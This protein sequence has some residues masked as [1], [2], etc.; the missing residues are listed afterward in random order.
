MLFIHVPHIIAP[1]AYMDQDPIGNSQYSG[2]EGKRGDEERFMRWRDW[3]DQEQDTR[4]AKIR[5]S[6]EAVF[7]EGLMIALSLILIPVL[8]IPAIVA[9]PDTTRLIFNTIDE[10][11]LGVFILEYS[12]KLA[13][14]TDRRQF[15]LNPWHLLDLFII[16]V[17]VGAIVVGSY[18]KL[19]GSLRLLRL[20][21][22]T[23]SA[24]LGTRVYSRQESGLENG[25]AATVAP[26]RECTV[27][28]LYPAI[29]EN[30]GGVNARH[31]R[32]IPDS[33]S[34]NFEGPE[35]STIWYDFTSVHETDLLKINRLTGVSA[36]LLEEAIKER[37][38]PWVRI[39]KNHAAVYLKIMESR[40]NPANPKQI[41]IAWK[42][43]LIVSRDHI[44]LTFSSSPL[45]A[46]ETLSREALAARET[47]TPAE[48]TY[49]FFQKALSGIEETLRA[50]ED[51]LEYTGSLPIS[52]QPSS[53]LPAT[54]KLKKESVKM[55]SWLLHT[56][57]VLNGIVTGK[58]IL[59]GIEDG[60]QFSALLDR[61]SYLYDISDDTTENV[62]SLT[63]YY[64]NSTS[65]QMGRVMKL[66]A[67]LSALTIIPTV[68]GSLL[69]S[70]LAGNPWPISLGQLIV[71]VG[72]AMFATGWVYYQLGWLKT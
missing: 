26:S 1:E 31:L 7:S 21:R 52:K 14:A 40:K 53:F 37:A 27:S 36:S 47:L 63:D 70:N 13:C 41:F 45:S 23:R 69:G 72:I 17:P 67:V 3:Q 34:V 32:D 68:V 57:D 28:T 64:F 24:A 9:V 44:L 6:V 59:Q 5:S 11:I 56:K 71:L 8:I 46:P 33:E 2:D 39:H 48:I 19:T 15:I 29:P 66:I 30:G 49:R 16:A 55:H 43:I 10:T 22:L 35:T 25:G 20:L 60:S 65:F 54:F 58:V 12:F 51:E 62:S 61:A 18:Q 38:F 50:I 42:W 4:L